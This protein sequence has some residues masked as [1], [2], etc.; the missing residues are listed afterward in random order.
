MKSD[1]F[2]YR[3]PLDFVEAKVCPYGIIA[4]TRTNPIISGVCGFSSVLFPR[5]FGREIRRKGG[6]EF[7]EVIYAT[8][9]L[10]QNHGFAAKNRQRTITAKGGRKI[11][12]YLSSVGGLCE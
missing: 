2:P 6:V 3:N 8:T 4:T 10:S 5:F 12:A 9:L 11:G 7:K 1:E